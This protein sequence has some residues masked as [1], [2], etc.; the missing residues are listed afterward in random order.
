MHAARRRPL[1]P[2]PPTGVVP[3]GS[4]RRRGGPAARARCRRVGR[5]ASPADHEHRAR[6][7]QRL[8]DRLTAGDVSATNALYAP[9]FAAVDRRRVIGGGTREGGDAFVELLQA[10]TDLGF[11]EVSAG[12]VAVR[13][14]RLVLTRGTS[15]TD[16]GFEVIVLSVI[17]VD[18]D[19]R[20]VA[21]GELR[22]LRPGRGAR[23][24]R[25]PI[26]R[27]RGCGA[28]PGAAGSGTAGTGHGLDHAGRPGRRHHRRDRARPRLH[29]P[30]T[31]RLRPGR[32]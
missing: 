2:D 30:P 32:T 15:R 12:V 7:G 29:R 1:A 21:I 11:S 19:E 31:A 16:G 14:D 4:L 9:T 3:G 22:R 23:R 26:R 18:P 25:R 5:P 17:E 27:G 10:G 28:R 24:A 20:V 13:G 8:L 6:A